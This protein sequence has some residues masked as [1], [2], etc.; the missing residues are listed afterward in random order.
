MVFKNSGG[1]GVVEGGRA[2]CVGPGRYEESGVRRVLFGFKEDI[3]GLSRGDKNYGSF[4]WFYVDCV[5]FNDSEGV[6]SNAKKEFVVESSINEAEEV[7]L[8]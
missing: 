3:G 2:S 7:G 4:E 1:G 6:V 5:S 8:P